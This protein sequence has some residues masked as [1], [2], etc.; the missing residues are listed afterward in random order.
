M[1][2]LI[3]GPFGSRKER[4]PAKRR[5]RSMHIARTSHTFTASRHSGES[6]NPEG[7][8]KRG[9]SSEK[10]ALKNQNVFE[11]LTR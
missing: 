7:W 10:I 5:E 8:C 3:P 9:P 11:T 6:R 4:K 2:S 1:Y